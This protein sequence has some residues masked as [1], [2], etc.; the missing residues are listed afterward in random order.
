MDLLLGSLNPDFTGLK[1]QNQFLIDS[2][3]D[4]QFDDLGQ[5]R[6][7]ID[8]DKLTQNIGKIL[9][10]NQGT[11][12]FEQRYGT[13][14][15]SFTGVSLLDEA[16]YA[17]IKQTILDALGVLVEIQ[18][19]IIN[20]NEKLGVIESLTVSFDENN[21]KAIKVQLD[22]INETGQTLIPVVSLPVLG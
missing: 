4:L 16:T 7:V 3:G 12:I 20:S 13:I 18:Q 10:T 9:L 21:N 8:N 6:T 15:N 11:N 2:D 19:D 17:A 5:L 1:T 22:V 14:L